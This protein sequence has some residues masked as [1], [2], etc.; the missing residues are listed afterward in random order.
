VIGL[1]LPFAFI[2]WAFVVVVAIIVLALIGVF[3]LISRG[4]K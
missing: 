2:G 3:H 4:M 1:A